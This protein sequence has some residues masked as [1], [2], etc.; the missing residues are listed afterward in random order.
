M[1]VQPSAEPRWAIVTVWAVVNAVNIVQGVGFLSRVR[2]GTTAIN[3]Y[4]GFLIIFLALPASLAL[5]A[6]VRARASW[7]HW[8]GPAV[9]LVF[10]AL[11]V[12]VD[13]LSPVEFR[14]PVRAEILVPFLV[15]F[16]GAILLMG[17]PMFRIDR[18][19]W[20]VTVAT[21][22]FLLGSMVSAMQKGVG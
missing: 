19:L 16:F 5:V 7:F 11:L 2:T 17:V 13:Y 21:T 8:I 22:A 3:H 12:Y 14:S 6:F 10:V 18:R 20:L 9:F 15:L 4:L 1:Q